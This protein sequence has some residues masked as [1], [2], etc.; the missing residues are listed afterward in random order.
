MEFTGLSAIDTAIVVVYL[1]AIVALGLWAG[2]EKVNAADYFL[3]SRSS[4]WPTIGLALL[5]SNISSTTLIGLAGAAYAIGISVYN[6][7]WMATVILAFFCIFLLPVILRSQV[8]T[9]PEFLEKR[10]TVSARLYFAGLTVFLNIVVDTASGLFAG[11]LMFQLILPGVP[12]WQIAAVIALAAGIYTMVGGLKSVLVTEVVQAVILLGGSVLLT[13]FALE[14]A[15][16]WDAVMAGVP[17]EKMSLIRPLDD[18]GVPWLGLLTGVPLLGLY[19]WCTNQFMVQRVLSAKNLNHGRWGSLFAGLLKLPLI[20]I[21]VLPGSAALLLYP[22]LERPDLVYPTLIFDLLPVGILGLVVAG[23]LAAIMSSIASTF[24]SASTLVTMDFARR[25]NPDLGE[26]SLVRIGRITTF[27]FM[28]LSIAWVP[29]V[30]MIAESLWQY[31]Q[32]V[33]AYAVP[34]IVAL[35]LVGIFW[36]RANGTGATVGLVLGSILGA[37]LFLANVVLGWMDLHF[38]YAATLLFVISLAGVILGS[39]LA[40]P[41]PAEK[42]ECLMWRRV[43][44]DAETAELATLPAWQNYR[45]QSLVLLVLTAAIVAAFW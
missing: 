28:L 8:F 22:N 15:G 18:A 3:A 33:L 34:P 14:K 13:W 7:E 16:G 2:R 26:R 44:F 11:A 19:F 45:Y 12:L 10:F 36:P 42:T 41:P 30:A 31:I 6:Y 43:D 20:Y 39:L 25:L 37:G 1:V 38:L 17:A 23:F 40:P 9:L 32:A 21:M 35:F 29:V 24:N 4:T 5:A 27:V